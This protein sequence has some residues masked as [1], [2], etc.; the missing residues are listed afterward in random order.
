MRNDGIKIIQIGM[1]GD[2]P[3]VAFVSTDDLSKEDLEP[4]E[5]W[6]LMK[7]SYAADEYQFY[8]QPK[9]INYHSKTIQKYKIIT[10]NQFSLDLDIESHIL[11][12]QFQKDSLYMWVL[13]NNNEFKRRKK[14]SFL[15][16]RTG[17]VIEYQDYQYLFTLQSQTRNHVTHLFEIF[18]TDFSEL[19]KFLAAQQW[20][21]ADKET[22][23]I[24]LNLC[25][26]ENSP[27]GYWINEA[28]IKNIKFSDLNYINYL[29]YKYS[30]G[31]FGYSI[32]KCIWQNITD[33]FEIDINNIQNEEWQHFCEHLGWNTCF[34]ALNFTDSAT[35]GHL[36]AIVGWGIAS[37]PICFPKTFLSILSH[38]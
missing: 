33:N 15:W 23:A 27:D 35:E 30:N 26:S 2:A 31:R 1:E 21:K 18:D 38:F 3:I 10:A 36:P 8:E 22:F 29:W 13:E 16:I 37:G 17:E 11:S 24:L 19:E 7:F 4:I 32:Q 25:G 14:R 5:L 9:K 12:I 20:E 34:P 28:N 6:S